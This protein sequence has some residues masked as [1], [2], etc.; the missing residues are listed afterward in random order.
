M[1]VNNSEKF[2]NYFIKPALLNHDVSV[3]VN[4]MFNILTIVWIVITIIVVLV[5]PPLLSLEADQPVDKD[6]DPEGED[7]TEGSEGDERADTVGDAPGQVVQ[8]RGSGQLQN[9]D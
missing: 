8:S 2:R 4:S 3:Q 1:K 9:L 5:T 7:D 6:G